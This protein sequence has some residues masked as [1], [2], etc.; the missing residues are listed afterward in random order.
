MPQII[1]CEW[2]VIFSENLLH[3]TVYP[4]K[5]KILGFD[6]EHCAHFSV[7]KLL[8]CPICLEEM[9]PPRRIFQ[10]SNGHAVCGEC[11]HRY[12]TVQYRCSTVQCSTGWPPAPSAACASARPPS[13]GTSSPRP[14]AT[15]A[16]ST[17]PPT[18]AGMSG[19]NHSLQKYFSAKFF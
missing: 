4:V 1:V 14:P 7:S 13:P 5:E 9:R 8:E 19:E 15:T 12:S 3:K 16:S 6:N 18:G 11:R 17:A 10:C 2:R